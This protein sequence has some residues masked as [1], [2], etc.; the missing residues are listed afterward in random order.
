MYSEL[1]IVNA[2][3]LKKRSYVETYIN[4]ERYRFYNG[5]AISIKCFPNHC[6]NLETKK[7]VLHELAFEIR[8]RLRNGWRPETAEDKR[9]QQGLAC[10][11]KLHEVLRDVSIE[12]VSDLYKRDL[13]KVG[14]DFIEYL[15][16]QGHVDTSIQDITGNIVQGFLKR[17]NSSATYY[18]NKRKTLGGLFSRLID[19]L[20]LTDNPVH[21]TKCKKVSTTLN[22]AYSKDQMKA[23]LCYLHRRNEHL[24]LCA[25]LMFGCLLRPHQEIRLLKRKHFNEDLTTIT[26]SGNE[27]KS[28][29]IRR[30]NVP[31]YVRD[32]LLKFEVQQLKPEQNIFTAQDAPFNESYFNTMWSKCKQV[33]IKNEVIT[34]DQTLY[35]FRHTAAISLYQQTKDPYVVQRALQ[36]SSLS[37]SLTYL[38][39]LGI[40]MGDTK[41][42]TPLMI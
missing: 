37:T 28:R 24:H 1:K 14:V 32:V 2:D 35:S 6:A 18:M 25:L 39:S 22:Q 21:Y 33:L 4:G 34:R 41:D 30:V 5:N 12:D 27:N 31:G 29:K 17:Y 15:K 40:L 42:L 11:T 10:C 13:I 20:F 19:G 16:E 3:N 38:R 8:H 23:V 9:K 26:L 36:H 7:K